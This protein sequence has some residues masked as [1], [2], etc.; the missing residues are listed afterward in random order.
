[1]KKKKTML[2]CFIILGMFFLG[3][4]VVKADTVCNDSTG[5]CGKEE[6]ETSTITFCEYQIDKG[7]YYDVK[8]KK[9]MSYN[10]IMRLVYRD[11][12]LLVA[13][14][15]N[16]HNEK[17][18]AG[19]LVDGPSG[20]Y[21]FLKDKWTDTY[22]KIKTITNNTCPSTI[23]TKGYWERTWYHDNKI[24]ET[25][26][27]FTYKLKKQSDSHTLTT[28]NC[29]YTYDKNKPSTLA[30][31]LFPGKILSNG[32]YDF[33]DIMLNISPKIF[34]S[35]AWELG[36][37]DSIFEVH[38]VPTDEISKDNPQ[39]VGNGFRNFAVGNN[40]VGE[41]SKSFYD[42]AKEVVTIIE[43]GCPKKF[44]FSPVL[45]GGGY[46]G[47]DNTERLKIASKTEAV[48]VFDN[49]K[50]CKAVVDVEL[51]KIE[52]IISPELKKEIESYNSENKITKDRAEAIM[53]KLTELNKNDALEKLISEENQKYFI[54]GYCSNW[55]ENKERLENVKEQQQQLIQNLLDK[56]EKAIEESDMSEAD[57]SQSISKLQ[58]IEKMLLASLNTLSSIFDG[59]KLE[60]E[61]I[62][63]DKN[64]PDSLYGMIH[65]IL[66][67]IRIL[68]PILLILLGS[69]DFGRAV[70]ASDQDALKKA[71]SRFIKRAIAAIAVF[72]LPYFIELILDII[73]N[74]IDIDVENCVI[75]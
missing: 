16:V 42:V 30:D 61:D 6:N 69:L 28:L 48:Y 27:T 29:S 47:Q 33:Y 1:M 63:G 54:D 26:Y 22:E 2:Y 49:S 12:K 70:L 72:F 20:T 68:V 35:N 11:G 4:M 3:N 56:M 58:N 51:A 62:F 45:G 9:S 57:K 18:F 74:S 38:G 24:H 50:E 73:K 14:R 37:I 32:A 53:N 21:G 5:T 46:L 8:N 75:K 34:T 43:A 31:D 55:E 39:Y 60:C 36:A 7:Y 40:L 19:E 65:Q 10:A 66:S 44:F 59:G 15:N 41:S 67:F 23:E 13:E 71:Q 52:K 64:D 17:E 25:K